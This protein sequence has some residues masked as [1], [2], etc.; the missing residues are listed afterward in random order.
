[1]LALDN[2]IMEA[3]EEGIVIHDSLGIKEI[4]TK[5]G[6]AVGIETMK[7][8]SVREPD[9]AFNPQ[10]DNTCTA[11]RLEADNVIV[12]IGQGVDQAFATHGISYTSKGTISVNSENVATGMKS[13]F[14]GGDIVSGATTVIQAVTSAREAVGNI[15]SFF[16]KKKSAARRNKAGFNACA[17]I[18]VPRVTVRELS[19]P[20][21]LKTIYTEDMPGVNMEEAAKEA[22]RCFNCGCLAVA[23]SDIATALVALDAVIVT[24][25]RAVPAQTFFNA[26]ATASTILTANELIKEIQIP[27]PSTGAIQRYEKFTLRKPIDFA[28]VS[29]ASVMNINNGICKDA[30]IVL[31]AVAPVPLRSRSA[32]NFLKGK[33][34]DEDTALQAGKIALED[35]LPLKENAYKIQIAKTLVKRS[36]LS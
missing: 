4:V 9:G 5:E 17:F 27:K 31:G 34:I 7:C 36:L 32:E 10:Y 8:L 25:K 35:A 20:D 30:R 26:T 28:I 18:D 24:S 11:L 15:E 14:A 1:M 6:K 23:P 22:Q 21:R 19:V 12:A 2:E 33:S 3:E 16:G 13:V 29:V